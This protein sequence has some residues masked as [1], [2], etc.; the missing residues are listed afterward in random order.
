MTDE[1]TSRRSANATRHRILAAAAMRF[2]QH[3]YDDTTLRDIAGDVGVDV[4]LVHRAFGSKEELFKQAVRATLDG[5]F[6][7]A[8]QAEEPVLALAALFVRARCLPATERIDPLNLFVR[9][10]NSV[11][12]SPILRELVQ[13]DFIEP[14]ALQSE[15]NG[16]LGA[17]MA[18][19]CV[20][21]IALLRDV[22][23]VASLRDASSQDMEKMVARLIQACLEPAAAPDD[24]QTL[25]SMAAMAARSRP[26][27]QS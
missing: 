10:L 13:H 8:T 2:S 15:P 23:G 25:P 6:H 24:H 14:L 12:A 9:S 16:E 20:A 11:R 21:G 17:A 19:G 1:A 26:K 5:D 18:M 3:S 27:G 22:L 7:K 4:A